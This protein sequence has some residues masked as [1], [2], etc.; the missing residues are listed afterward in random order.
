LR[1]HLF[2]AAD[3][4]GFNEGLKD[5]DNI[6]INKRYFDDSD[7]DYWK[8]NKFLFISDIRSLTFKT[9]A[10]KE[11]ILKNNEDIVWGDM[12]L[13]ME[14]VK[15][16]EP[17]YSLLKFR[18]PY[19]TSYALEQ[20]K[21]RKYLD[22]IIYVQGYVKCQSCETRLLVSGKDI[23]YRDYDIKKYEEKMSYHNR[24]DRSFS[25]INPLNPEK[26]FIMKEEGLCDDFDSTLFT[27]VIMDYVKK[28]GL[29]ANEETVKPL[30]KKI[31]NGIPSRN[32]ASNINKL[33]K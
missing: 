25:Y 3:H 30:L 21:T 20:G 17:E 23:S 13:Q 29:D 19:A 14:W 7:V 16:M 32:G 4:F 8:D 10:E 15:K 24:C 1:F 12:T 27:C 22:G 9:G 18:L 11:D 33:K 31:L 2:D 26:E 5:H 28:I 6:I